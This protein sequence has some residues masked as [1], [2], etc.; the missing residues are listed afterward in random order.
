[1]PNGHLLNFVNAKRLCLV[2]LMKQKHYRNY[3]AFNQSYLVKG[4]I[5]PVIFCLTRKNKNT[6][7]Y[8]G[9]SGL[10]RTSDFQKLCGSELDRI[11][12]YRIRTELGLKN[13]T[14]RS[15]LNLAWLQFENYFMWPNNF[16]DS[17]IFC[18]RMFCFILQTSE[19]FRWVLLTYNHSV[20]A[21]VCWNAV[22]SVKKHKQLWTSKVHYA[23]FIFVVY[24]SVFATHVSQQKSEAS[25][26]SRADLEGKSF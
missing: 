19:C 13:F 2:C 18:S 11:Q 9:G 23:C 12:F 22:T 8:I 26:K 17:F 25:R 24:G 4:K 16:S 3:F 7:F 21:T 20:V 6:W 15:S 14:V 1:M 5:A 10:D